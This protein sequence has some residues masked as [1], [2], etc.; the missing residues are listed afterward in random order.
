MLLKV[1]GQLDLADGKSYVAGD[2]M[3]VSAERAR[4]LLQKH[5]AKLEAIYTDKAKHAPKSDKFQRK[6]Q[7]I[8]VK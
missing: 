3:E 2:V 6:N 8:Q 7:T 5:S 1:K 4:L